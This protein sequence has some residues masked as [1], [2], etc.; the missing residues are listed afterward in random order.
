MRFLQ[1]TAKEDVGVE[2]GDAV[3]A[4]RTALLSV[5]GSGGSL[6]AA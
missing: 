4:A 5:D 2:E 6:T 3:K 1:R